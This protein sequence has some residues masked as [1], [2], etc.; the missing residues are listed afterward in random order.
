MKM[1]KKSPAKANIIGPEIKKKVTFAE[2]YKK[3]DMKTY[4]NQTLSEYTKEAKRQNTSKAAGKGYDAPKSQM[5][6]SVVGPKTKDTTPK[7]EVKTTPKIDFTKAT[8]TEKKTTGPKNRTTVKQAKSNKKVG[9]KDAKQKNYETRKDRR[10]SIKDARKSGRAEVK[11]ARVN[12]RLVKKTVKA[13]N[14]EDKKAT[15]ASEKLA[16]RGV[17]KTKKAV[18]KGIRQGK[19]LVKKITR[20]TFS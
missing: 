16:K 15:K 13:T 17:R 1:M 14:K 5:K 4:G 8:V 6:G 2:A 19:R 10:A 7:K 3:R 18:K 11:E 20:E 12:K 9:V